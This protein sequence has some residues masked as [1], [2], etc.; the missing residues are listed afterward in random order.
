MSSSARLQRALPLAALLLVV[1]ADVAVGRDHALLGVLLISPLLAATVLGR[2]ATLAYAVL[3]VA[4]VA[5]IGAYDGQYTGEALP[6]QLARLAGVGLGGVAAVAAAS[7]RL[8]QQAELVQLNTDAV[9]S[10]AALQVAEALQRS[11]LTAPPRI[12]GLEIEVRYQP[13]T[14]HTEVGGDWYDVFGLPDGATALVI[15]DVAGHDLPA[16]TTM[17]QARGILRGIAQSVGSHP[18]AV[19][20][21]LD[22]AL[23][24]LGMTTLVTAVVAVVERVSGADGGTR[25]RWCNAGHPPPVLLRADGGVG[26]LEHAPELLLGVAPEAARSDREVSLRAGDTVLFY[27]D[28]LVERPGHDLDEGTAVLIGMVQRLAGQRLHTLCDELLAALPGGGE[29]DVALLAV[30]FGS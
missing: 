11:L 19:L 29:D 3:A 2:W 22:R 5:L 9:T 1:A 15:G 4:A 27:T 25:L 18:A 30:R 24:T 12:P 23:E 10:R 26:V 8:R 7:L 21:A 16:A 20:T 13:A 17:A 14:R 6:A 28:G